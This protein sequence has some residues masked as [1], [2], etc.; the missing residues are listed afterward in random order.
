MT[1]AELVEHTGLHYNTVGDYLTA[2]HK[3]GATHIVMWE[4]NTRG[5]AVHPIYKL[6]KGRDAK[7][8]K[9]SQAER[10]ARWRSKVRSINDPRHMRGNHEAFPEE[11]LV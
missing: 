2:L 8:P 3:A 7:Q 4:N 6:G 5:Q 11:S 10:Q 1:R 9:L